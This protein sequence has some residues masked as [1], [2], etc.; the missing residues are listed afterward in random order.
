MVDYV[1]AIKRPFQDIPTL[2]IGIIVGFIPIVG[3]LNLGYAV[4]AA[5]TAQ[6]GEKSL[7]KWDPNQI[8]TYIKDLV[9]VLIISIIYELP[10]AILFAVA[11]AGFLVGA[12]GAIG[13][14]ISGDTAALTSAIIAGLGTGGVFF[15]LAVILGVVGALFA[16]MGVQFYIK[17][18]SFGSAFKFS[19]ILKKVLTATYWV[20]LIVYVI[21]VVVLGILATIIALVPIIG[22][23]VAAGVL[24]F[25][26]QVTMYTLMANVFSETP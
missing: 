2:I 25:L 12:G 17:E 13:G 23:F 10:A 15:L 11:V 24:S 21:Y 5:R 14:L 9:F 7:P 26:N 1:S 6:K 18:G 19:Q 4:G 16:S 8:V 22:I 20:T 3:L